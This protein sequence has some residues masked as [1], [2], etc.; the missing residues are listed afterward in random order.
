[1]EGIYDVTYIQFFER[2]QPSEINLEARLEF[3]QQLELINEFNNSKKQC[4]SLQHN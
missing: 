3:L 4:G 2:L 1:M